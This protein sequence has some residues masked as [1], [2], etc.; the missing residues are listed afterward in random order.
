MKNKIKLAVMA[1]VMGLASVHAWADQTNLVRNLDIELSGIIQGDTS[2]SKNVTTTSVT[3]VSVANSDIIGAIG[4][5]TGNSFSANAQLVVITPVS[6]GASS[7]QIRDGGN[8]VDVTSF[9]S[10]S[11]LTQTI[12][13]STSNSKNGKASGSNYSLQEFSLVDAGGYDPLAFHYSVT[14][15][16]TENFSIPAIPGPRSELK[17][18]V[19]G[20]GD[21]NGETLLLQ[22][23]IKVSGQTV[24]VVVG[25][26]GPP[27]V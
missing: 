15:I 17:A 26:G 23:T 21:L 4:A 2:T 5:V 9:F 6:A 24:E 27:P 10:Q 14:G 1:T 8:K 20:A 11:I 19:S 7:I 3:K 25:G 18:D 16:A 12:G 13:K 22:G